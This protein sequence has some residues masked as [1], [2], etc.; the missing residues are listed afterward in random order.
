MVLQPEL[1]RKLD[2]AVRARRVRELAEPARLAPLLDRLLGPNLAA[3]LLVPALRSLRPFLLAAL[4]ADPRPLRDHL[5]PAARSALQALASRPVRLPAPLASA[6]LENPILEEILRD[7]LY[8]ALREFNDRVNPFFAEWGAPSI[9]RKVLPIGASTVLRTLEAV[10]GEFDRRLEP[11]MRRFLQ[12]FVRRGLKRAS[13]VLAEGR[14]GPHGPAL[15]RSLMEALLSQP[16]A[17]LSEALDDEALRLIEEAG[18]ATLL[19]FLASPYAVELR[20]AA[21]AA[22]CLSA[23]ELTLDEFLSQRGILY[24]VSPAALAALLAHLAGEAGQ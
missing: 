21:L 22:L 12:G 4:R 23:G 15:R 14:D 19:T 8:E 13:Q 16:V 3:E 18:H 6:L 2:A 9:I 1:L 5:P 20:R 24:R 11:E 7:Q 17:L 10:R